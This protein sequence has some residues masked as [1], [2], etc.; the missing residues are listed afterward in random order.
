M[1]KCNHGRVRNGSAFYIDCLLKETDIYS[2]QVCFLS[3]RNKLNSCPAKIRVSIK[4]AIIILLDIQNRIF[5]TRQNKKEVL[6]NCQ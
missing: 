2:C 3:I 4:F 1:L 6:I 5:Y